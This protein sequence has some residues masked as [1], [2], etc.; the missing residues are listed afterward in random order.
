MELSPCHASA[1]GMAHP[2]PL[3][4]PETFV[5]SDHKR[6]HTVC[7]LCGSQCKPGHLYIINIGMSYVL[8]VSPRPFSLPE[9]QR[10]R[11]ESVVLQIKALA[12]RRAGAC[13]CCG[14]AAACISTG[15]SRRVLKAKR[16]SF[17]LTLS[18]IFS[19][20]H[21]LTLSLLHSLP[22]VMRLTPGGLG[23][24]THLLRMAWRRRSSTSSR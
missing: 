20:P 14:H 3:S 6:W 23:S 10:V 12:G 24:S 9:I 11:L 16:V 5:T 19:L 17:S 21:P 22:Q 18:L 1:A 15:I 4:L 8:C 13:Q 7:G 2:R